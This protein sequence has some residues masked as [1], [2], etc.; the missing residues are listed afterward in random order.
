MTQ[1]D[2]RD[3]TVG[4]EEDARCCG[5]HREG[6]PACPCAANGCPR[7][8]RWICAALLIG[9]LGLLALRT[10]RCAGAAGPGCCGA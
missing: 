6:K 10:R 1:K 7:K 9:G 4:T 5:G 8:A 3:E 2:A